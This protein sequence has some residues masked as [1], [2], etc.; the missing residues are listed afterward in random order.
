MSRTYTVRAVAL[1]IGV[2]SKWMDN[3]LSRHALPGVERS[4]QGVER[5]I[6]D[7]GMLATEVARI[8]N[9]ELGV[10]MERAA[11]IARDMMNS[12]TGS[13]T[14]FSTPSGLSLHFP[15][16]DIERRL[17]DRIMDA[18]EAMARLPRGRPPHT[19]KN[20]ER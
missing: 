6:T 9:I 14:S 10:S 13:E 11:A 3:L 12:R 5:R 7:E 18:L 19:E 4:R 15:V 1:A 8:L 17:R 16:A 2:P 20:A